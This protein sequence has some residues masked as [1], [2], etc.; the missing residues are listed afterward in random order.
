MRRS[1]LLASVVAA[2]VV[3]RSA[4]AGDVFGTVYG[5]VRPQSTN[6]AGQPSFARSTF[7]VGIDVAHEP[8]TN[9]GFLA[10]AGAAVEWQGFCAPGSCPWPPSNGRNGDVTRHGELGIHGRIGWEWRH[11]GI[12]GGA[13]M[14]TDSFTHPDH[15]VLLAPDFLVRFGTLHDIWFGIGGGA[16]N[17]PTIHSPGLYGLLHIGLGPRAWLAFAGGVHEW[18]PWGDRPLWRV[19]GEGAGR[20]GRRWFIGGGGAIMAAL[21]ND[22]TTH[23]ELRFF[24]GLEF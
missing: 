14:R 17:A 6:D 2:L 15:T 7:G 5:G 22:N 3:A 23:A 9:E 21:H 8:R 24:A 18:G 1:L 13:L 16:Y 12:E 19:D 11:V 4:H 20:I 10:R